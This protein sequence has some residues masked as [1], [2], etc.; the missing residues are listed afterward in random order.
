LEQEKVDIIKSRTPK[1]DLD[2]LNK[3]D[4][5]A[6]AEVFH[7][8]LMQCYVYAYNLNEKMERQK[9]DSMELT[10]RAIQ[11]E[12]GKSKTRTSNTV[13][14]GMGGSIFAF[15]ANNHP[16]AGTKI[17]LFSRY[18]RVTDRRTLEQRRALFEDAK[19]EPEPVVSQ[20]SQ[21]K[22]REEAVEEELD[23]KKALPESLNLQV[24]EL[25]LLK[26]E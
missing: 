13:P 3:D 24:L 17:S 16:N 23:L 15:I 20:K 14:T 6:Q 21:R 8:I 9:Y 22:P 5:K 25:Q 2:G 19:P 11:L 12:K 18:E 1:L 26:M 7:E 10:K 4:L